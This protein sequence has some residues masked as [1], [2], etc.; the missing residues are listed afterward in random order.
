MCNRIST[1][2][3]QKF[4]TNTICS[5]HISFS[6]NRSNILSWQSN[7][8]PSLSWRLQ[9]SPSSQQLTA[10]INLGVETHSILIL[11]FFLIQT[12]RNTKHSNSGLPKGFH[13]T[14]HGL[15]EGTWR[16]NPYQFLLHKVYISPSHNFVAVQ[17]RWEPQIDIMEAHYVCGFVLMWMAAGDSQCHRT[18]LLPSKH[19][20]VLCEPQLRNHCQI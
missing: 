12:I 20:Q 14:V 10:Q 18:A 5:T 7:L 19:Q 4:E 9:G 11:F 16:H 1:T 8:L 3:E 15:L 17:R 13:W 2:R 6:C